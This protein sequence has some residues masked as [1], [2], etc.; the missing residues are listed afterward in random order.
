[1]CIGCGLC[2][3]VCPTK[4]ILVVQ[5]AERKAPSLDLGRC[6]MC[7]LCVE[8]CPSPLALTFTSA[9]ELCEYDKERLIYQPWRLSQPPAEPP[10]EYVRVKDID[11]KRLISHGR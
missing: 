10:R 7:G 1:G 3:W 5:E 6:C 2:S 11:E 4:A 8:I 9:Y